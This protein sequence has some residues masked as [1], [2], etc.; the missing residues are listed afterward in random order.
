MKKQKVNSGIYW[1]VHHDELIEVYTSARERIKYIKEHKPK[2]QRAIRLSRMQPVKG[3][4]PPGLRML[5]RK[6]IPLKRYVYKSWFQGIKRRDFSAYQEI[7]DQLVTLEA[8]FHEL[9]EE[10]WP[11]ILEL[12]QKECKDCPWRQSVRRATWGNLFWR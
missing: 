10:H 7:A 12:H 4:L 9:V 11:R 2:E 8:Q 6:L 3:S 5:A 1:H